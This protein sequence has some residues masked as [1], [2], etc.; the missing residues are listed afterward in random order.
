MPERNST[1][2]SKGARGQRHGDDARNKP[3]KQREN[4]QRLGV[5]ADHKT[6]TMKRGHRG[7]FP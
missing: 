6:A 1:R 4:Q 2:S 5:G 7:T 3:E